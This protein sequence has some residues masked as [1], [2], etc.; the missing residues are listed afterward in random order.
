MTMHESLADAYVAGL[1]ALA[2]GTPVPSVRD[3]LSKASNFGAAD[4]PAL[5]LLAHCFTVAHPR[6]CIVSSEAIPLHLP[7]CF[8]LLAWTLAGRD[9]V[10]ALRYYRPGAA[11][12]SDDGQTLSGAFGNRLFGEGRTRDQLASVIARIR[13]DPASRRTWA[14]ILAADDNFVDSREYPCAAGVQLFLRDGALHFLTVMRAQQALTVL[15][16]DAFLFMSLQA[17]AT[18]ALGAN[19]GQYVHFA[20]T[21]HIYEAETAAVNAVV[22][23]PVHDAELP[24]FPS[25]AANARRCADRL[26]AL[27]VALRAAAQAGDR[28]TL[29][30][31][32]ATP[33]QDPFTDCARATLCN[34]AYTIVGADPTVEPAH[35]VPPALRQ[36]ITSRS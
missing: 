31:I 8:A 1:R 34:F 7:Y 6:R 10:A 21:F 18:A 32:A 25:G 22:T 5:E 29:D 13:T 19:L 30:R 4:R 23:G 33:E 24:Q 2:D 3:P 20:G 11:E 14:S 28:G 12:F 27:E 9:D 35:P 16:Y 36:L 26:T 17:F 15:P